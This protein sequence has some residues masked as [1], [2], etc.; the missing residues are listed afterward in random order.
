VFVLASRHYD[1]SDPTLIT[2]GAGLRV[3]HNLGFGVPDT[4][5]AVNLARRWSNRPPTTTVTYTATNAAAIPDLGLRVTVDGPDLPESLGSIVA[6]PGGGPH[7]DSATELY[8]IVD[9]GGAAEPI[10]A[11]L[12]G[13]AALIQR[14]G[15]TFFC[16]KIA[17]AAAAGAE[18]AII[19]NNRGAEDRILMAQTDLT[20]I[21][22]L[23][24]AQNDGDALRN[25]LAAMPEARAGLGLTSTNYTFKVPETLQCEYVGLRVDTDHTAR[26]DLRV[27][28]TSPAGTRSIMQRVNQDTLPGPRDWTYYSVQHFY[29]S[30]AGTWTVTISDEDNKGTGRVRRI[31][32]L[33]SGVPITDLD[34][35]GL[36]DV[37]EQL[38]FASLAQG[39]AGDPDHDGYSNAREQVLGS[40]PAHATLPFQLDLSLW[41][42]RLARLSWPSNTNTLYRVE[43]GAES[44]APLHLLT[45]IPGGFPETEWFVPYTEGLH[46][47]FKVEA[48]PV[49]R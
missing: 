6:L 26:G 7:P 36:D 24:I 28:L 9:V 13:K 46:H 15:I 33:I 23:F 25:Y 20:P 32:L 45:T 39:P 12:R 2:N 38:Q 17:F 21:P 43:I 18:L 4:G 8:P 22:S 42:S 10:E 41:D 40:D 14:D 3:S 19:S 34:R 44:A 29:E 49:G 5:L 30:S 47:F 48:V 35:D 16:Q 27:V 11:D 31:S 37:W 1:F